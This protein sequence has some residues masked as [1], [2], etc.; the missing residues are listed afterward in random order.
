MTIS[1]QLDLVNH[2]F[3]AGAIVVLIYSIAASCIPRLRS[4]GRY[5]TLNIVLLAASFFVIAGPLV[6][7]YYFGFPACSMCYYQRI[8][9]WP[10]ALMAIGTSLAPNK[11]GRN[12]VLSAIKWLAPAGLAFSIYHYTSQW[13]LTSTSAVCGAVGQSVSC[14]GID[15]IVWG[16]MTMPLMAGLGFISL[17]L[18]LRII[19]RTT[20]NSQ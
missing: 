12:Y 14:D 7:Q 13:G 5:N 2:I 19:E 18:L 8:F 15:V 4:I 11:A 10:M 3:A 20:G 9:M 17:F 16:F 6:Y 1:S